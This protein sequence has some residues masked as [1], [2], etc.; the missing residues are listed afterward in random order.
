MEE[1]TI[2]D[3]QYLADL[4]A[5]AIDKLVNEMS[6]LKAHLVKQW[7]IQHKFNVGIYKYI[8]ASRASTRRIV[9]SILIAGL[10]AAIA[11]IGGNY[12]ITKDMLKTHLQMTEKLLK[13]Q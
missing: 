11:L 6:E 9:L 3:I 12:T 2:K 1:Q 10:T 5:K 13:A 7:D 8:E 4:Q